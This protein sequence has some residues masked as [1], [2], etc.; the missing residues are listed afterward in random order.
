MPSF[1]MTS[2]RSCCVLDR[3]SIPNPHS[4]TECVAGMVEDEQSRYG[5]LAYDRTA[6]MFRIGLGP[7]ETWSEGALVR[8]K[9]VYVKKINV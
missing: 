6:L 7:E 4:T 1:W 9:N 8:T 2:K 3:V 5:S